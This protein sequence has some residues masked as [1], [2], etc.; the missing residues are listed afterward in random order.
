LQNTG[1]QGRRYLA[2]RLADTGENDR[3]GRDAGGQSA[4]HLP[5][6]D[7]IRTGAEPGERGDH[8]LVGSVEAREGLGEGMVGILDGTRCVTVKGRANVRRQAGKVDLL[9]L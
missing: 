2:G 5:F 7:H 8:G 9:G 1:F 3:I 4:A 6:R